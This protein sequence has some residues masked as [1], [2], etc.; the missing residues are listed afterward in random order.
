MNIIVTHTRK[1]IHTIKPLKSVVIL[2]YSTSLIANAALSKQQQT[3]GQQHRKKS[4]L[5]ITLHTHSSTVHTYER[6]VGIFSV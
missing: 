4:E 3:K 6:G 2:R 1:P 5:Y